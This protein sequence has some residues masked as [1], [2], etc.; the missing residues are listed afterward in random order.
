MKRKLYAGVLAGGLCVGTGVAAYAAD[1]FG[2][3]AVYDS[4]TLISESSGGKVWDPANSI[5]DA[6]LRIAIRDTTADGYST[7][8]KGQWQGKSGGLW[9]DVYLYKSAGVSKADGWV[10]KEKTATDPDLSSS[11]LRIK[12]S[13]CHAEPWYTPDRCDAAGYQYP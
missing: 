9:S 4:G 7:Y 6:T 3:L 12:P 8:A 5:V 11:A 10:T 13:V 1:T 2:R